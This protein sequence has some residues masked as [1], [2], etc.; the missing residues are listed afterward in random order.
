MDRAF[1]HL[2]LQRDAAALQQDAYNFF[3]DCLSWISNW[4][5]WMEMMAAK[6]EE[7]EEEEEESNECS[8]HDL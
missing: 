2:F 5:K 8:P 4:Q 7:E 3:F 6:V 1:L